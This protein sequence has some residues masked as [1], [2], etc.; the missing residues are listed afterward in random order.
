MPDK[1]ELRSE[2]IKRILNK[3]LHILIRYGI[4]II[5]IL[6][7]I[8]LIISYYIPY[9][10]TIEFSSVIVQEKQTNKNLFYV[11]VLAPYLNILK[12]QKGQSAIIYLEE[13]KDKL[14]E[15]VNGKITYISQNIIFLSGKS[16][17]PIYIGI[18]KNIFTKNKTGSR[19]R[20]KIQFIYSE[21]TIFNRIIGR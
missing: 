21:K 17:Y 5:F 1:A 11:K 6:F 15:K 10:E 20:G 2:E 9:T 14:D 19:I 12:I 16:Y 18:N 3:P 13:Y 8:L 7:T 4:S